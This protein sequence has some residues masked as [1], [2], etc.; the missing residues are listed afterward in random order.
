MV[1]KSK[2][3]LFS[4]L[5]ENCLIYYKSLRENNKIISFAILECLNYKSIDSILNDLLRRRVI[6]YYSI[7][8]NTNDKNKKVILL[9]FEESKKEN[10][11][12][13]FNIVQQNLG[14]THKPTKFLKEKFLEERFLAIIFK[15]FS[16]NTTI[17][18]SSESIIIS[19]ENK[20]KVLNFFTIDFDF[21]EKKKS[22]ISNFL[23]LVTNIAEKGFLILNFKIENS[24]NI[25]ISPYFV[26]ETD[27]IKNIL[28]IENKVNNFF[29]SN[30][31]K[32]HNIK[33]KTFSNFLWRLGINDTFFFLDDYYD[34]FY[35]NNSS[36]SLDLLE[37]NKLIEENLL[38]NQIEYMRL[39]KNLLFIEQSYVFLILENLDCDNIYK[40]IEKYHPKYFIYILILND[41]GNKE[42][43]KI[44]SI[45]LI[46]NIKI[47]NP[48]EIRNFNYKEFKRNDN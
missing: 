10:I 4:Y 12:K 25:K 6:Q 48:I 27:N 40:I 31:L 1:K 3:K 30:L 18:K 45:K 37:M 14:E 42:L 17:T 46:E 34:L 32:R 21:I 43:Q 2:Y 5:I 28:N 35:S 39:S 41:L 24:E 22:F 47:V 15:N 38:N 7:Q 26:L 33:I 20:L 11:I 44:K 23:N 29:H 19:T 36:N 9:N 16:S 13:A 8:I